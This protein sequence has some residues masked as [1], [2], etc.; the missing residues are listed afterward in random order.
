MTTARM[1]VVYDFDGTLAPGNMQDRLFMP[2]MGITPEEF[3]AE[4]NRNSAEHEMDPILS[5]MNVMLRRY[6]Q[7]GIR[8]RREDLAAK[9]REIEFFPGVEGWFDRAQRTRPGAETW[10]SGT[11]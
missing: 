11:S 6:G 1:A 2:A 8:V 4:V 7:A 5:Y 3:W 9:S 10:N